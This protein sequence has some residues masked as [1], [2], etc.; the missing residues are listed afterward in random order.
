MREVIRT[1]SAPL[2]SGAY[3]QAIVSDG[4]VFVAGQ[5]PTDPRSRQKVAGGVAAET[6]Q[7]LTNVQSI[8]AAAG[9]SMQDVVK[10]NVYLR[11]AADFAEMNAVYQTFWPENPPARTTVQAIPPADILVEIDCIARQPSSG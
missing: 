8:L 7:T 5:G 9:C 4:W 3:S 11:D 6:R 2:P 1:E 10:V